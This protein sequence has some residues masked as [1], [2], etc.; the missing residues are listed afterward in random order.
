LLTTEKNDGT[1]V[2][3]KIYLLQNNEQII[4]TST[5]LSSIT[6][7]AAGTKSVAYSGIDISSGVQANYFLFHPIN[8]F[9]NIT[10]V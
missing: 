3:L 7:F 1:L 4:E 5:K 9:L 6:I 8:N 10:G 2:N